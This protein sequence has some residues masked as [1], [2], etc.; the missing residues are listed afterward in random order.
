MA[1]YF[2]SYGPVCKTQRSPICG[3]AT[4]KKQRY[5]A[6]RNATP[7]MVKSIN[8][9]H[10]ERTSWQFG[11]AVL[12]SVLEVEQYTFKRPCTF[13]QYGRIVEKAVDVDLQL[14]SEFG[15]SGKS[16]KEPMKTRVVECG[17]ILQNCLDSPKER[18]SG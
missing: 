13:Y 12:V 8:A 7:Q 5:L 4:G 17:P 9:S 6:K 18:R 1:L 2:C 15:I 11:L 10:L 16:R 3:I 14:V